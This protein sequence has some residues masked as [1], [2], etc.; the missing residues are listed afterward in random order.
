MNF[1]FSTRDGIPLLADFY[2]LST[3]YEDSNF[4]DRE[5][6]QKLLPVVK[7]RLLKYTAISTIGEL[8]YIY[9]ILPTHKIRIIFERFGILVYPIYRLYLSSGLVS[10]TKTYYKYKRIK[11]L[12]R[13]IS[14][15][16][17]C[18]CQSGWG[19]CYGGKSWALVCDRWLSLQR[20]KRCSLSNSFV[21]IDNLIDAAHNSGKC[22]DK[23]FPEINEWLY[24][25]TK[26]NNPFWVVDQ[27]C[28]KTYAYRR[29]YERY[30]FTREKLVA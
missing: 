9:S 29:L 26:T 24:K 8:R 25:K 23:I 14:A 19:S 30:G 10:K 1:D 7:S 5:I 13:V 28:I 21:L 4:L 12:P 17:V 3:F 15:A 22:L 27:S 11:Q 16:K 6:A 20:Q 2:T 18:F